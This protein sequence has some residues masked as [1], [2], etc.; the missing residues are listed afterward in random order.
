M[1]LFATLLHVLLFRTTVRT[2]QAVPVCFHCPRCGERDVHGTVWTETHTSRLVGLVQTSQDRVHWVRGPCC[3][4]QILAHATPEALALLDAD[5]IEFQRLLLDRVCVLK[6]TLLIAAFLCF[7]I[8]IM[9]PTLL[10][11]AWLPG[12]SFPR[13]FQWALRICLLIHVVAINAM[14]VI[15]VMSDRK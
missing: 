3:D 10:L 11:L 13:W 15:L 8:P 12:G 2:T 6:I 1:E 9:G 5:T 7:F 14:F 4:R